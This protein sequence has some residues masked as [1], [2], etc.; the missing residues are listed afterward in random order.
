MRLKIAGFSTY[1]I[2]HTISIIKFWAWN[3]STISQFG[4]TILYNCSPVLHSLLI[5][6]SSIVVYLDKRINWLCQNLSETW[7]EPNCD[8]ARLHSSGQVT[9]NSGRRFWFLFLVFFSISGR[10]SRFSSFSSTNLPTF[11]PRLSTLRLSKKLVMSSIVL[12][13]SS[14]DLLLCLGRAADLTGLRTLWESCGEFAC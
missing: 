6:K 12:M 13:P 10:L 4:R 14:R 11:E 1:L 5:S 7:C 9:T 8:H 3:K 2:C